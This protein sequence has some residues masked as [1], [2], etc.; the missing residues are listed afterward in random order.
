MESYKLIMSNK[1]NLKWNSHHGE[2]FQSFESLRQREMLVDVTLSCNGQYL[3][4]HKLVLCAGS[5]Y[6]ERI[7]GKDGPGSS[8]IHFYGVEMHLLKLLVEF[9]YCGEVEVP[10]VDLEVFIEIA[11]NLEVKGLKGDRSKNNASHGVSGT[12]I[13]ASDVQNVLPHKRKSSTPTWQEF[14]E[15]QF[16]S[17]KVPRFQG[18]LL[19]V[20]QQLAGQ[21]VQQ[22]QPVCLSS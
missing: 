5:G 22:T 12:T 6:F 20:K 2:T 19:Q 7:L 4:A 9:M 10:A 16:K 14:D 15:S 13:P 8:T 1:Y 3:K 21:Q 18:P 11:E 17:T